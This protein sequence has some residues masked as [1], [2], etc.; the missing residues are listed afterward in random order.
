MQGNNNLFLFWGI[1]VERRDYR[2][3][4]GLVHVSLN[5]F[6]LQQLSVAISFQ[7]LHLLNGNLVELDE[8]LALWHAVID[9]NG[10]DVFH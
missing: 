10:I 2:G 1:I 4:Q 6:L 8:A 7:Y 3:T 5:N 9:E